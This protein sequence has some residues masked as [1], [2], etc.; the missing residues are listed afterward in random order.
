M[1][2]KYKCLLV[3]V[4]IFLL[5]GCRD[6]K[7]LPEDDAF[8]MSDIPVLYLK[9]E[10]GDEAIR[11][12]NE[13]PDHSVECE[14]ILDIC[15]PDGYQSD[16]GKQESVFDLKLDYI[17]GRGNS[18][19]LASKKPYKVKFEDKQDLFGMGENKHWVL[20]ANAYD[21][22]LLRNRI[23]SFLGEA[24]GMEFTPAGINVDL[25]MN[26]E[27]LGNYYLSEQIRISGNRVDIK[28]M[29]EEDTEEPKIWGG[30]LLN[31]SPWLEQDPKNIFTSDNGASFYNDTPSY[32]DDEDAFDNDIQRDYI[33]S[34]VQKCE[35]AILNDADYENYLDL[36]SAA[37]YWLIQ[38]FSENSDAF[39]TPSTYMYKKR[40]ED[41]KSEG[42]LYFGPL[43]DFDRAWGSESFEK[44]DP[45]YFNHSPMLWIDELRDKE[46]FQD[47]LKQRWKVLDEKLEEV[48]REDG[49]LDR[50][51]QENSVSWGC[52]RAKWKEFYAEV[53]GK[54]LSYEDIIEDLRSWIIRRREWINGH[55]DEI[56]D[57]FVRITL[58]NDGLED[59]VL[60]V[61]KADLLNGRLGAP[62]KDGFVF[63]GWYD[64]EGDRFDENGWVS[65]DLTLYARYID[66]ADAIKA[67]DVLFMKEDVY[68]S[69]D[70]GTYE[71]AYTI[72]PYDAQE[73]S[74]D[75]SS[76]DENVARIDAEGMIELTGVG[77]TRISAK[78]KSGNT[79]SYL[80]HVL[81]GDEENESPVSLKE[82]LI[83][84]EAGGYAQI[85]VNEVSTKKVSYMFLSEDAQIAEVNE[86]GAIRAL[87]KGET[88]ISVYVYDEDY[89]LIDELSC[90]VIVRD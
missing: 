62:Y 17:R 77:E 64:E 26:G 33:R 89:E 83:E 30:Y 46:V 40:Y 88:K 20:L 69:I 45:A 52:D 29:K 61:K 14:G 24:M 72:V 7:T 81:A 67:E 68:V 16:F 80:L 2:N 5:C 1:M 11:A 43:W 56:G 12:M 15:V 55:I 34:Y 31:V 70:E 10:G 84:A 60:K 41:D 82:D 8:S 79:A 21:R 9:L 86:K 73:R 18:T 57:V 39:R 63:I 76:E 65:Q 6:E 32:G 44:G 38:E 23:T 36:V 48:V 78:L 49:C 85:V 27:Y 22:S 71:A 19:W 37:D 35:D 75:W 51:S 50:W 58:K 3:V 42:K 53:S 47:L 59:R 74:I 90:R 66:E 87:G 13:S 54:D 4:I 28:E 25:V